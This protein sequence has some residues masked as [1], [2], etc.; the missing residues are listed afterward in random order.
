M[1]FLLLSPSEGSVLPRLRKRGLLRI[2][3]CVRIITE[4]T[5]TFLNIIIMKKLVVLSVLAAA[6]TFASCG[7]K[8]NETGTDAVAADSLAGEPI[9]VVED[10]AVATEVAVDTAVK[11]EV[12]TETTTEL[13][14]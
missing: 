10:T 2:Y 12:K 5:L 8:K 13:K 4:N 9:E 7:D 14:K 1:L 11:T 6:F 3:I